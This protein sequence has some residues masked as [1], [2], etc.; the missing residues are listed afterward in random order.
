MSEY[1]APEPILVD[2]IDS[3]GDGCTDT[4]LLD[5]DGDGYVDTVLTGADAA[6]FPVDPGN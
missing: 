6:V 5:T 1:Y 2:E 3:D 4:S